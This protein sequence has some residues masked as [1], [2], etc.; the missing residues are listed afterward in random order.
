MVPALLPLALFAAGVLAAAV[1]DVASFTI[2]NRL[3]AALAVAFLPA[4]LLVHLPWGVIG[5]CVLTGVVALLLGIGLFAAGLCGGGDAKLIAACALWLGLP[6]VIPFLLFTSL[7]GGVLG[8]VV[9]VARKAIPASVVASGPA[10]IG[11]LLGPERHLPYG[12][13]IAVGAFVA[14]PHSPFMTVINRA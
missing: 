7:A 10:W 4:A 1:L 9:L 5:V 12:V 8:I 2:P 6:A 14:L 11:R 3:N 13:A